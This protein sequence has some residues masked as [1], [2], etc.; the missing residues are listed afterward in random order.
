MACQPVV[1]LTGLSELATVV[2]TEEECGLASAPNP[3]LKCIIMLFEGP[4]STF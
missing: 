4:F 1:C 3:K 2:I